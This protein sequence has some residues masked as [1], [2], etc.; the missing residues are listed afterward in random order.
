MGVHQ[1]LNSHP[2]GAR[3]GRRARSVSWCR[4][5]TSREH[6]ARL[7]VSAAHQTNA[8]L[9]RHT[10]LRGVRGS[11]SKPIA[12]RK[13]GGVNLPLTE[14]PRQ[15]TP[16]SPKRARDIPKVIAY[17]RAYMR[18]L[19]VQSFTNAY[20]EAVGVVPTPPLPLEY[21]PSE[22]LSEECPSASRV[23]RP[24]ARPPPRQQ[25]VSWE[26]RPCPVLSTP[27]LG[28]GE[29]P[30][31]APRAHFLA[32]SPLDLQGLRLGE[33]CRAVPSCR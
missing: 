26:R 29:Q 33:P 14:K 2:F 25:T 15:E 12:H 5:K 17:S 28:S 20:T 9:R 21:P 27:V 3:H 30:H 31:L 16:N 22:A 19:A 13:I 24:P 7:G 4:S 8:C 23:P 10:V 6:L 18:G 1:H 11:V 32:F